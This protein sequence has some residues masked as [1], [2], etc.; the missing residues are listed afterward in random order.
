MVFFAFTLASL[1]ARDAMRSGS[2]VA[3]FRAG[4]RIRQNVSRVKESKFWC[5]DQCRENERQ[6]TSKRMEG[7]ANNGIPV[8]VSSEEGL[9][10]P[11]DWE[12]W[13]E[14]QPYSIIAP[15]RAGFLGFRM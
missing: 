7:R 6:A 5:V 10:G 9:N 14:K 13:P 15:E 4:N 2:D 8:G 12:V 11:E 1:V 3:A